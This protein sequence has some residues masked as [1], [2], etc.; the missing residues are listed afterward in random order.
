MYGEELEL[1][2]QT[3][4]IVIDYYLRKYSLVKHNK[5]HFTLSNG[6]KYRI[7]YLY[8]EYWYLRYYSLFNQGN[9]GLNKDNCDYYIFVYP[10][11]S[12]MLYR[13][14]FKF[15][16]IKTDIIINMIIQNQYITDSKRF[17]S[18]K[19]KFSINDIINNCKILM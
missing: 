5:K 12:R 19:Y 9:V 7:K 15:F 3:I 18:C 16:L 6:L 13:N 14:D 4:Y 10:I 17:F 8:K 11:N 1:N 2:R